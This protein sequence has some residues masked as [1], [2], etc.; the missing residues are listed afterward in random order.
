MRILKLELLA[1][2]P[3][4]GEVLDFSHCEA[5]FHVVHG[6]N[7]AGKSSALRALTG[8]LYGIPERTSDN[9]IH[10][11]AALRIGG[12]IE[13]ANGDRLQFIRRKG[14]THT[15]L[16]PDDNEVIDES[17]LQALLAG[18]DEATFRSRFG[19]DYEELRRG[20]KEIVRGGG[21]LAEVLFAAGS[22]LANLREIEQKLQREIDDLF[23]P[24]ASKIPTINAALARLNE[25]R[26]NIREAMLPTSQWDHC[27][28]ALRRC[29]DRQRKLEGEL[30]SKRTEQ[31]R[32]QR[33]KQSLPLIGERRMLRA[34]LA[35]V[36][37]APRL[38]DTFSDERIQ[39]Q[40]KLE[41]ARRGQRQA[42]EEIERLAQARAQIQVPASLL[43]HRTAIT[44][45]HTDLGGYVKAAKDRPGLVA[46]RQQAEQ[47]V[48]RLLKEL[49]RPPRLDE[50]ESLRLPRERRR[51]ILTLAGEC[52]DKIGRQ[53]A[54]RKTVRQITD[55]LT[56]LSRQ[57][58]ELSEAPD[59]E[60]LEQALHRARNLGDMDGQ[61]RQYEEELHRLHGQAAAD[62]TRLTLFEGSLEQLARLAI[63]SLET[64]DRFE[65]TLNDAQGQVER[66][67][68]QIEESLDRRSQ[69]QATLDALRS[70]QDVPT[71]QGLRKIRERRDTGWR[72][73]QYTWR[74]GGTLPGARDPEIDAFIAE[75]APDGD[76]A[77]AYF[78]SVKAAD[79]IADRLRREADRVARK[80]QLQADLNRIDETLSR[81]DRELDS[82]RQQ[83]DAEQNRWR[84]L[85]QNVSIEPLSPREMRGWRDK[86]Q[87]LVRLADEICDHEA[88]LERLRQCID[89]HRRALAA[90]LADLGITD[91]IATKAPRLADVIDRCDQILSDLNDRK[92]QRDRLL[93]QQ[94]DKENELGAAKADLEEAASE[95]EQWRNQWA[96][97]VVALG[98]DATATPAQVHGVIET[99][100]ELL[101][102]MEEI[103]GLDERIGGIDA[104]A[105]EYRLRV[106]RLLEQV[107][108][109]LLDPLEDS[110]EQAVADLYDRLGRA[111]KDRQRLEDLQERLEK[112]RQKAHDA[113]VMID[114]AQRKLTA[115]CQEAGCESPD[116]L[117]EAE[118]RSRQR[119]DIED[120]LR[121]IE[122]QLVQL[123]AG[124]DL[125]A[126]VA[127]LQP[128]DPDQVEAELE[129][130]DRTVEDLEEELKQVSEAVGR[131]RQ[132]LAQMDGSDRAAAAREEIEWLLAGIRTDAERYVRLKLAQ[133]VLAR[134]ME[135]FRE[136]NQGPVLRRAGRLFQQLTLGSFTSIRADFDDQDSLL[137]MG[138]R[139]NGQEILIDGMSE[140]TADQLYLALRLAMLETALEHHEPVPFV[141]DDILI[142]FDDDRTTAA[143]KL[144]AA[145]AGKT[146][147]IYFTHHRHIIELAHKHLKACDF[148][149][150]ELAPTTA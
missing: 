142:M 12:E 53:A 73:V 82:A 42:E 20:G 90:C 67:R 113:K 51:Q 29:E 91:E 45:L 124:K 47:E 74:S 57:L 11:N 116:Q 140:G 94:R 125:E 32:L 34:Q 70:E 114:E 36:A 106:R 136:R 96:E 130:L 25:A 79:D 3:F 117:R 132:A 48:E 16:G 141:V 122:Q 127:E 72:L 77:E 102:R 65:S 145:L 104:D 37:D 98:L 115:L 126:W 66:L 17:R 68:Q 35:E 99:V 92:R 93:E 21:R 54:A 121:P 101:Q 63:P 75:F 128:F 39:A 52:Q 31:N 61:C 135:R 27:E 109:D 62:L 103:R 118:K 30:K 138:V 15:L 41:N 105:K 143:L 119:K 78:A 2:G 7:E 5:G 110:V 80:A 76:L 100:D 148:C 44:Q 86:Q 13:G 50:V 69:L 120:E 139:P 133:E 146:Q 38:S 19:I 134:A 33:V 40:Q 84:Q 147:V 10:P 55:Q 8:W 28:R 123:A 129:R 58:A 43:Q 46:R 18:V 64:I 49:G 4:T 9:F 81:L 87:A 107:A 137:L 97:A 60:E 88:E 95:L 14:R 83:L 71:E 56:K 59:T 111:E 144:F 24:R 108:P 112:E 1:F 149:I 85:W 26:K 6:P 131:H 89:S 23:K 150:H 22:G